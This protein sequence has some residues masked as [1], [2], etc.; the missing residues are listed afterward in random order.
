VIT[1]DGSLANQMAV[2]VYTEFDYKTS[3]FICGNL[4]KGLEVSNKVLG[5]KIN[6]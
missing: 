2:F 3:C 5:G 1:D 6:F 4:G